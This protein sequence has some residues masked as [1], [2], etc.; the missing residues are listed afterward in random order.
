MDRR[1]ARKSDVERK[2]K[3]VG[4]HHDGSFGVYMAHKIQKL[5]SQNDALVLSGMSAP[6]PSGG[7]G[8]DASSPTVNRNGTAT[9]PA[10][11]A[12][13]YVYVDGYTVPSKE[14]I[15]ELLLTHGG[16]FEHYET[17]KVTH[18]VATHLPHAKVLQYKKRRRPLPVV[19][20]D[21]I[22][23]SVEANQ[24]LP[25]REYVYQGFLDPLQASLFSSTNPSTPVALTGGRAADGDHREQRVRPSENVEIDSD[26]FAESD[27][28]D[29]EGGIHEALLAEVHAEN[30]CEETAN[31]ETAV[32]QLATPTS[33]QPKRTNSSRDGPAFVRHF[34]AKSRLHHIG[35]WKTTFQ[36][37]A[38]AFRAK[39]KGPPIK[40]A[41]PTSNDRVILHVDM[42]CFFV[43]VAIRNLPEFQNVPVAVAHSENAGSSEI[44][45]CNYLARAKGVSAG[46]FMHRARVLCPELQVLPY[47]FEEIQQV[48][49]QIYD[50]F[51]SHTPHVQAMSCDEAFLEFGAGT[52]GMAI[53]QQIRD[54]IF[55]QT[56]CTASVGISYNILLAKLATKQAKPNGMFKIGSPSDAEPFLLSL[57]VR[58]L[59]GVGR[60]KTAK[61]EEHGI[62]DILQLRGLTRHELCESL[63]QSAGDMVLNFARGIDTR[64][65]SI[66]AS[67]TRKS[68]SAVINFG[69]RFDTWEDA[70]TFLMALAEELSARLASLGVMTK[71]LTI[72]IKKR[73]EG[74]PVEPTKYLGC[75]ICDN[76]SS[77][78]IFAE[79][80]SDANVIGRTGIELLRRLH[81]P[82]PDIRGVGLQATKLVFDAG[83]ASSKRSTDTT[84]E[85]SGATTLRQS[86]DA[87]MRLS[88]IDQEVLR[89]LPEEIQREVVAE[90][91][92][93]DS[94]STR[95]KQT[96]L[97]PR[98]HNPKGAKGKRPYRKASSAR[99][100]FAD[101]STN[102]VGSTD[103]DLIRFSQIDTEVLNALPLN[104]RKEIE[105]LANRP[106]AK[107]VRNSAV[108]N[109]PHS[110]IP[111]AA[112]KENLQ[113]I[114]ALFAEVISVVEATSSDAVLNKRTSHLQE[115][116]DAIYSRILHE[117]ENRM[118]DRALRM[119]RYTRRKCDEY[120]Q[121]FAT[122]V[123][124]DG[125]NRV[126]AQI[127]ADLGER[128]RGRFSRTQ[129]PPL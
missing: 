119:L 62:Q 86:H 108:R 56:K 117:V 4:E 55:M 58:D 90:F 127:N 68:V 91:D 129:V 18:I 88:Q 31:A 65:L 50:I 99:A 44:S 107:L 52:D 81:L 118:L 14:E 95:R 76:F 67:M 123:L 69:I 79:P 125:F 114:E 122:E 93:S 84:H 89:E 85:S 92:A 59:P 10:V 109:A 72:Q 3:H 77:S 115:Q 6:S 16:G 13:V 66:E 112:A 21:W 97:P 101:A 32:A 116:F 37:H 124:Q 38:T 1:H 94:I 28:S 36:Q 12:G 9:A 74:Q 113:T 98:H 26:G 46:M 20:P 43:A 73:R 7:R 104:I 5:R 23:K 126:L 120:A 57:G 27:E 111:V 80:T 60:S 11:F 24:L 82:P 71:N 51:F 34:F 105:G 17:S 103:S 83:T 53:A 49:F 106:M 41:K 64:Q 96:A 54:S 102:A 75:G 15:R 42:D 35:T 61:L 19:H 22:V 25:V 29:T 121:V 40:R 48:S 110:P 45:S 2:R 47:K 33:E 8:S 100:L 63:G 70:K 30:S 78:W 128:F 87:R 39:Y